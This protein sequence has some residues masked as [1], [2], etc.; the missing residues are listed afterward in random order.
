MSDNRLK[1]NLENP[2]L[3]SWIS[4]L[5]ITTTNTTTNVIDIPQKSIQTTRRS[6]GT[7]KLNLKKRS[8]VTVFMI[9]NDD[10]FFFNAAI[11]TPNIPYVPVL[12]QTHKI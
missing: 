11:I 12:L 5:I 7:S 4:F 6:F 1:T 10:N 3:R 2:F 8:I 9:K